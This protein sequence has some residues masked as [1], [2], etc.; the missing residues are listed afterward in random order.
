MK[1]PLFVWTWALIPMTYNETVVS[2]SN[3]TTYTFSNVDIWTVS[4]SRKVVIALAGR[5]LSSKDITSVTIGWIT[6]TE[7]IKSIN[8]DWNTS[9]CCMCSADVSTWTNADVVITFNWQMLR[10]S[11]ASYS[12]YWATVNTTWS[13]NTNPHQA[14]LDWFNFIW[15][16]ANFSADSALSWTGA[17]LDDTSEM[18]TNAFISSASES[19]TSEETSHLIEIDWNESQRPVFCAIWYDIT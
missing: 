7:D 16:S 17:T 3:L 1:L 9:L 8:D 4:A 6:A 19:F 18:E 5:W 2:S 11:L 14:T 15:V 13:D 12:I 10:A